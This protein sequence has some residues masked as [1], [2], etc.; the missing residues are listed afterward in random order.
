[1][2]NLP[3]LTLVL[4]WVLDALANWRLIPS[5][6]VSELVWATNFPMRVA[7][8]LFLLLVAAHLVFKWPYGPN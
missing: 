4:F 7:A 2:D 6:T 8:G 3:L 1:M 5:R